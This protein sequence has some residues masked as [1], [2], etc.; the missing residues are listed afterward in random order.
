MMTLLEK[1][2]LRSFIVLISQKE[3]GKVNGL[4]KTRKSE[5]LKWQSL[6]ILFKHRTFYDKILIVTCS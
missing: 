2:L 3:T 1:I 5:I 4:F 6:I